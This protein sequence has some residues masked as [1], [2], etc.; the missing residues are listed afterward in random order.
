MG[1]LARFFASF[2]GWADYEPKHWSGAAYKRNWRKR[3]QEARAVV[4]QMSDA[5]TGARYCLALRKN[6]RSRATRWRATLIGPRRFPP[7]MVYRGHAR[8]DDIDDAVIALRLVLQLERVPC[9]QQ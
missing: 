2:W 3:A 5:H 1:T 9:L 6:T 7:G 8:G 4:V